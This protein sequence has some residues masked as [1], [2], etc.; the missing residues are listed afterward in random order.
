M[1]LYN[2]SETFRNAVNKLWTAV[3]EGFGKIK[4]T[5]LGA[6]DSA[7]Q[8]IEEVKNKFLNSGIGQSDAVLIPAFA[9]DV[10]NPVADLPKLTANVTA[11]FPNRGGKK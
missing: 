11:F 6:L 4:E 5:I 8:K 1:L 2:K 10:T 3:K 9:A 7:K